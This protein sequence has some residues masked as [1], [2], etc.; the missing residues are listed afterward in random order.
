ML[1]IFFFCLRVGRSHGKS[2][3]LFQVGQKAS[4]GMKMFVETGKADELNGDNGQGENDVYDVFTAP[5]IPIGSGRTE[6]QFIVDGNHSLV[7]RPSIE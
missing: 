2:Y 6:T 7:R 1:T 3:S 5:A 4:P